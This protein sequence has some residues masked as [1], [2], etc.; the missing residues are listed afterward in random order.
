MGAGGTFMS[1]SIAGK[2][3]IVTG[4]GRGI[5]LAIANHFAERGARVMYADADEARLIDELGEDL[6]DEKLTAANLLSATVSAFDRVDILVNTSRQ[7][8]H[9][10]PLDP[11]DAAVDRLLRNNFLAPLRLMQNVA[12]RMI[13]QADREESEEGPVGTIVNVASILPGRVHPG[14]LAYSV[15]GAA[16][17]Q[18]TRTMAVALAQH[19][20]RVNGV[21]VASVMSASLQSAL[22]ENPGW[23]DCLTGATPAGRIA[24]P[25]DVAETV[26]YLASDASAFVTGQVLRVDG[27]RGLLDPAR[28]PAY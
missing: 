6:A 10:D 20:I 3:A 25:S 5:G 17:D 9:S 15:A 18:A 24:A 26:Q 2:C 11:D 28:V 14:L 27:G 21:A 13:L 16:L 1:S 12:R 7:I 23:R 19:R 22:K 4:A 8:V